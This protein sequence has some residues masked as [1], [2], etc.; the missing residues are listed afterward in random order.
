MGLIA[1]CHIP[2]TPFPCPLSICQ[3]PLALCLLFD[4]AMRSDPVLGYSQFSCLVMQISAGYFLY[5]TA[6]CILR[7]EHEGPEFLLHGVIS[8]AVFA[9]LAQMRILHWFGKQG[10]NVQGRK[11]GSQQRGHGCQ[12]CM[13]LLFLLLQSLIT[14]PTWCRGCPCATLCLFQQINAG[15]AARRWEQT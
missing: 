7:F 5:D 4:P 8:F 9:S 1:H 2:V 11:R 3:V 13:L 12:V 6:E 15:Q 14:C 10:S